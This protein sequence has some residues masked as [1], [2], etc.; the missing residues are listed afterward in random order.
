M[1]HAIRVL[2]DKRTASQARREIAELGDNRL[3]QLFLDGEQQAFTE[4]VRRYEKR[5]QN[6][7]FGT[8]GDRER[9]EDLIQ[10]TFIR[11]YRHLDRFDQ[12]RK[13]S[14]WIYTIAG[15]LAKNELRNRSRNPVVLFQALMKNWEAD[16]RPLEWEDPKTRPDDLYRRRALREKVHEAVR[17][18]SEHHQRRLRATRTARQELRGDRRDHRVLPGNGQ[19]PLEPR[20]EQLRPADRSDDRIDPDPAAHPEGG[21]LH[22][23]GLY[24]RVQPPTRG[25]IV[26]DGAVAIRIALAPWADLP[27]DGF[28]SPLRSRLYCSGIPNI[29]QIQIGAGPGPL[30]RAAAGSC[31]STR[32]TATTGWTT[33]RGPR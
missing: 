9:A 10:E 4:L 20:P 24:S 28:E 21:T 1:V 11:V 3:V 16:F 6:F 12:S 15:N 27:W 31:N 33:R 22:V 13:F 32:I 23:R 7:V 25:G 17:K 19:E 29:R 14:T 2:D 5:L 18:L 26:R 30:M 8:L